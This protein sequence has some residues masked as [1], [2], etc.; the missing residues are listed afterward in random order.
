MRGLPFQGQMTIAEF[1]GTSPFL[2]L[3]EEPGRELVFG[4]VGPF[5]QWRRGRLPPRIPRTPGEFAAAL[6]E[7]RMAAV[8]NLRADP[9]PSGSTVWTETW[10][11]APA[12]AQTVAFTA[13][14]LLIGPFSAWI[15]RLLLRAGRRR[16]TTGGARGGSCHHAQSRGS[17]STSSSAASRLPGETG[18]S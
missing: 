12:P 4:V 13:Y 3:E 9:G 14:W 17:R 7:G 16:A 6:A 11:I 1:F 5:W 15:R 10:V 18:G 8:G 2:I